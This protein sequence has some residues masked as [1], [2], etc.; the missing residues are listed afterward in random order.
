MFTRRH[1]SRS[2]QR[3]NERTN[4]AEQLKKRL[5][6]FGDDGGQ[7]PVKDQIADLRALRD[8]GAVSDGDY[9]SGVADL[10]GTSESVLG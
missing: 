7:N 9:A 10:L 1:K 8:A 4:E 2:A 6:A 3:A 5:S